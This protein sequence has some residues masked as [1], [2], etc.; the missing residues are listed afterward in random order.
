[1]EENKL[2][3]EA[4]VPPE[5]ARKQNIFRKPEDYR[6]LGTLVLLEFITCGIYYYYLL[7]KI[8][9]ATNRDTD[10][11]GRSPAGWLILCILFPLP[12]V[13]IWMYKT[14]KIIEDMVLK[15]TGKLSS[16]GVPALLITIF[17]L[18][19][20]SMMVLQN[21]LNKAVGGATGTAPESHGVGVCPHCGEYFPD[22]VTSCPNCGAAY[23]RP[24]TRSY[25]FA[26]LMAVL[27]VILIIILFS[28]ILAA[29]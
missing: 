1:M 15:S 28:A 22:D 8:T 4:P 18:P 23:K 11:A 24:F 20:V 7:V 25:T 9:Q 2:P 26:I 13:Y 27:V 3:V 21:Y 17:A 5:P 6:G 16:V 12:C 19:F 14:G 29:G 10:Y